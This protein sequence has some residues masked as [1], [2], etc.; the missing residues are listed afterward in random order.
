MCGQ[1]LARYL[2]LAQQLG[3]YDQMLILGGELEFVQ[4]VVSPLSYRQN[5][6]NTLIQKCDQ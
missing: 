5:T 2:Q 6:H 1:V 4:Y 3:Q